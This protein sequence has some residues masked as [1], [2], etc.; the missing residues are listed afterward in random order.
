MN[1]EE[2]GFFRIEDS[3]DA[4]LEECTKKSKEIQ[5]MAASNINVFIHKDKQKAT[6]FRKQK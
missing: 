5:I 3:V 4:T 2:T 6:K 1:I